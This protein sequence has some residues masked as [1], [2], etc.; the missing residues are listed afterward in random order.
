MKNLRTILAVVFCMVVLTS[1]TDNSLEEIEQN[2]RQNNIQLIE[3]TE[4][5]TVG[6]EDQQETGEEG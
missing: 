4:D 2:E 6:G 1:C 3:P 5:P